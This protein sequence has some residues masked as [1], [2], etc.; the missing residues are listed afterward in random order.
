M[1]VRTDND[2]G[3]IALKKRRLTRIDTSHPLVPQPKM[4]KP[5]GKSRLALLH[6]TLEPDGSRLESEIPKEERRKTRVSLREFFPEGL[7]FPNALLELIQCLD[8]IIRLQPGQHETSE[9][10]KA[11]E[12]QIYD[13]FIRASQ[14]RFRSEEQIIAEVL[15]TPAA[16]LPQARAHKLSG[17]KSQFRTPTAV[18]LAHNYALSSNQGRSKSGKRMSLVFGDISNV[19]GT[20]KFF[21][22]LLSQELRKPVFER[23]LWASLNLKRD[24]INHLAELAGQEDQ[25][26]AARTLEKAGRFL[27]DW[28][29]R[30]VTG[31]IK[32]TF[33]E[34][35][36]GTEAQFLG[37]GGDEFYI[38]C[39]GRV[40][41]VA[42][43]VTKAQERISA[44][45][46]DLGLTDYPHSK[47]D[48]QT[49]GLG[50]MMR[51]RSLN[52]SKLEAQAI[53]QKGPSEK[54][55]PEAN[56]LNKIDPE[57]RL[58][59]I[60]AKLNTSYIR[61]KPEQE[62]ARANIRG[63][64]TT[65]SREADKD[66]IVKKQLL[67]MFNSSVGT[68][69]C[70]VLP[71]YVKDK[72]QGQDLMLVSA[73][74]EN[75]AAIND[76][77]SQDDTD[78]ILK[79]FAQKIQVELK[80]LNSQS[81]VFHLGAG[82]FVGVIPTPIKEGRDLEQA[83][84][85]IKEHVSRINNQKIDKGDE[86]SLTI[87]ELAH[88]KNKKIKGV[89]LP[90]LRSRMVSAQAIDNIEEEVNQLLLAV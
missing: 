71:T 80:R 41:D 65:K 38:T 32:E 10:A 82:H 75:I 67:S 49:K 42:K 31:T 79:R 68:Y 12:Q 90:E 55:K 34:T 60:I 6:S 76:N 73:S 50:V 57:S 87:G 70:E 62:L 13:K 23:G 44:A 59:T 35:P 37:V 15:G 20:N 48:K 18:A 64:F 77:I 36:R 7:L 69:D 45:V 88:P 46:S 86:K 27:A 16:G 81:Q 11:R 19:G 21:I 72:L 26:S 5:F 33:E 22:D 43:I 84:E 30:V 8:A 56:P 78:T 51:A 66:Q 2:S 74:L 83:R 61:F 85:A 89:Y 39:P 17:Y 47:I 14:K 54:P 28:S 4:L 3:E 63:L 29:V 53:S 58:K 9:D 40:R 1:I 24:E 25:R 52:N